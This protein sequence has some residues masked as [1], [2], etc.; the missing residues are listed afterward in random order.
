MTSALKVLVSARELL[1]DEKRWTKGASARDATGDDVD[2]R[3]ERAVCWCV[4]GAVVKSTLGMLHQEAALNQV[5]DVVDEPIP[6]FNDAPTS[7]HADVLRAL[8][9]AIER[10]KDSSK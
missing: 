10:A 9:A 1:S 2:P 5:H 8:D 3:S 6:E 4:V 7:T